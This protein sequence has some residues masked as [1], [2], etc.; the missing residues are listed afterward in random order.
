MIMLFRIDLMKE[1]GCGNRELIP[2]GRDVPVT[3]NNIFEYIRRYTEYRLIKSQEKALEVKFTN[4][5]K[6]C[7]SLIYIFTGFKR[8][9]F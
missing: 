9:Y 3:S 6:V 4:F 7:K 1:E 2:G 5:T 8:R